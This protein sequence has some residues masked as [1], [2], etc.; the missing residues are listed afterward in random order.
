[1]EILNNPSCCK[2]TILSHPEL[3]E[4]TKDG[5]ELYNHC[6][7]LA[8]GKVSVK[9]ESEDLPEFNSLKSALRKHLRYMQTK[10]NYILSCLFF[11]L[12]AK[13]TCAQQRIDS[14]QQID[15]V[16]ILSHKE[17]YGSQCLVAVYKTPDVT[18]FYSRS[19]VG[20]ALQQFTS[21]QI[22]S[23][24]LGNASSIS[25]RGANDDHTNVYWNGLKINSLTLGGTDMSL[26]PF[27]SGDEIAVETNNTSLGGAVNIN[28]KPNW[29]NKF[30]L[31]IRS[32]IS[33]FDNYRNTLSFKIGNSKIQFHTSAFYH[34]AKN[35]FTYTDVYKFNNPIDTANHNAL[36]SA[37]TVNTV[38]IQ[39]KKQVFISIGSW[40]QQ[41]DKELPAIMG[42]NGES[43]KFQNDKSIRHFINIDK[44]I[45]K[46]DM[47]FALAHSFDEMKYTDKR[48]PTDTFLFI[49]THYI[50]NRI[51]N[52]FFINT[53]FKYHLS[54]QTGYFYNINMADVKEYVKKV[55]DHIGE[56]F[57]NLKW[58]QEQFAASVKITQP[59]SSF[60]YV[61]PQF[62]AEAGFETKKQEKKYTV[63]IS[64]SDKYRFPDLNDRYWNPG[65]NPN[66][67]PEFGWTVN[68]SNG[69]HTY[70]NRHSFQT[71]VSLYYSNIKNNIVWT[72]VTNVIWS[73]KN[74]KSTR[75][76][77]I[78]SDAIYSFTQSDKFYVYLKAIYNFNRAQ[79]TEDA[80][81]A[82][83]NGHYL[84]YKPQHTFK[85]NFYIE[86]K[87]AGIGFNYNYTSTRFTDEENIDFFELKPYHLLDVYLTFK[88]TIK[89]QHQLQFIF[90]INNI[91]NTSYESVRSYAQPQRYYS[92]SFIYNF[93][94]LHK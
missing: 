76:Y 59:F 54:L 79:I 53:N 8:N 31:K 42:S 69:F 84:R 85:T 30:D 28:S 26:I 82:D 19:D 75:L 29:R 44:T 68:L 17:E 91:T 93:L 65:G 63:N 58:K 49:N 1:M 35:N 43:S 27:E 92:L 37:G 24:G 80:N 81:N 33:S 72:P 46:G 55:T 5:T 41:K 89:E 64:Y 2:H 38:F 40:Y 4:G 60:K 15:T 73:P 51:S 94:K 88:G 66:L 9:C 14:V 86:Q 10:S 74:L 67:K 61:R 25:V 13:Y 52:S 39:L 3:V 87:Y 12:S 83:L 22:N 34:N 50:T 16:K 77:G 36:K 78:E 21:V 45:S 48:M 32:D 7:R 18:A 70:K 56:V 11:V 23:Y 62:Y 6:L 71:N 57:A 47:H 20:E 90:K